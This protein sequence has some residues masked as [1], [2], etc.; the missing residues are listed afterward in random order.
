MV[1]SFTSH[2]GPPMEDFLQY[3][4]ALGYSRSSYDKFLV[5]FD[6]FC[7]QAFPEERSLTQP[8]VMQ[9]VRLR[10]N[11]TANG[12]KRRMVAIR[13]LGK[14]LQALG[15][16]AYVLPQAMIGAYQPFVPYLFSDA[17]LTAF[18]AAADNLAPHTLSPY[19]PYIVPVLFRLLYCC[20]LRPQEVRMI[21]C[22]DVQGET[23]RIYI[24]DTK[25]HRDRIV[26]MSPD[27]QALCRR[28]DATMRTLRKDR[29][30]YFPHP[31]GGPYSANWVQLQFRHCWKKA[32]LDR[33]R[34]TTAP[35]VYDFRHNYATRTLLQW[36]DEG[37]ELSTWLPYLS[38]YMGHAQ[39]AQ[40]AYYIHLLPERLVQTA[41]IDWARFDDLI[42]EVAP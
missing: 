28:Y 20:G 8:L 21:R 25:V 24:R 7:L 18:F 17:E 12:V 11:E 15:V 42:P 41:A 4:V 2:L 1:T 40:T 36:M 39:F 19:R 35:R 22:A 33:E 34:G 13:E 16:E 30:Y 37:R 27:M 9:W 32:G 10:P 31:Q 29:D 23:G 38:A 26:V 3:K 14:Y 5:L 6:R